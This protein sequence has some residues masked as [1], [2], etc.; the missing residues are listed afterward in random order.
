MAVSGIGQT[1]R[2]PRPIM[3][4]LGSVEG[5]KAMARIDDA[6]LRAVG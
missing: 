5:T 3:T 1:L 2:F 6:L 4:D